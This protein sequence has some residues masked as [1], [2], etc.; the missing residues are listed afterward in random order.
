MR[1]LLTGA[2]G[3]LGH[4]LRRSAPDG[5]RLLACDRSELDITRPQAVARVMSAHAPQVVINAAAYTG[6][7]D[8]ESDRERAFAINA[9]GAAHVAEAASAHGTRCIQISTDFVFD[10]EAGR[11]YRPGDEPRPLS[12][13]GESKLAGERAVLEACGDGA[14]VVRTSWVYSTHGGN[15]VKSML[16]LMRER[17]ELGVVADQIGSPTW[18]ARLATAVWEMAQKDDLAGILHWSDAGVASWYDF[19]VA[20]RDEAFARSLLDRRI[21]IQPLTTE[22]FPRPAPRPASSVLD[23][24][25]TRQQLSTP[26]VHWRQA[27]GQMLDELMEDAY[28]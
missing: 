25:A 6:V 24:S 28:A 19:A 7:D 4:E 14:L 22:E 20:I 8:A 16:R 3:Q 2:S 11:P 9:T 17:S 21:P 15:F 13:Y 18:A 1:V 10:G 26:A 12:V 27:L 23:T 5:V